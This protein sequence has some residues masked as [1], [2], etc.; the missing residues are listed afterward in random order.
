MSNNSTNSF[1]K[2]QELYYFDILVEFN[3][4][5]NMKNNFFL[6]Y[7]QLYLI[8]DFCWFCKTPTVL[9]ALKIAKIIPTLISAGCTSLVLPVDVYM[10]RP[11]NDI[12]G[13][14]TDQ[15]IR[16][17]EYVID[18]EKLTIGDCQVLTTNCVENAW[19]QFCKRE[20]RYDTAGIPESWIIT[21]YRW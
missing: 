11:L 3:Y 16:D 12:I 13:T 18:F 8:L 14:R 10:N 21:S 17:C 1:Q 7:V 20:V 5:H 15:E 2:A 9:K 4:T 19:Y 6:K